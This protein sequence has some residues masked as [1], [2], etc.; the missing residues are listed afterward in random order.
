MAIRKNANG[1]FTADIRQDR[2]RRHTKRFKTKIEAARYE[3]HFLNEIDAGKVWQPNQKDRRKLSELI[4]IW[5][6]LHGQ[7]LRNGQRRT[8]LLHNTAKALGDPIA[9]DFNA[10][11][12]SHYRSK[13]LKTVQPKTINNEKTYIS[14]VFN[15]LRRL[16]EID[17]H[18]P[19]NDVKAINIPERELNY[20]TSDDIVALLDELR[21]YPATNNNMFK[22]WHTVG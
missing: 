13:R 19:L 16:K 15:E 17:Y 22:L 20:L 5:F 7:N 14:S 8:M 9:K 1:T 10:N 21:P 4:N 6:E 12:F 11:D 2:K 3:R 18:N